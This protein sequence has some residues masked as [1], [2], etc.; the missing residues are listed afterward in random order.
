MRQRESSELFGCIKMSNRE[1]DADHLWAALKHVVEKSQALKKTQRLV[2]V[3]HAVSLTRG[4]C[5][6]VLAEP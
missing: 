2:E 3:L 1:G 6:T 4:N 5:S